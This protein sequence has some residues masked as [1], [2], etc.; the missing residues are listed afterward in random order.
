MQRN[1][2]SQIHVVK[3]EEQGRRYLEVIIETADRNKNEVGFLPESVYEGALHTG[4]LWILVSEGN[5]CG[6]LLFGGALPTL[7]IKQLY[8]VDSMRNLGLA[9]RLV[10]DLITYGEHEGYLSIRARVAVDLPANDAWERLGF[11]IIK[12]VSG[13]KTT[14]RMINCRYRRLNPKGSQTHM[15]AVLDEVVTSA[16]LNRVA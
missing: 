2:K 11:Q 1:R 12:V 6:H 3:D 4:R 13:G 10:N 9:R 14:G 8:I 5:Y 15:L 7:Q 16:A